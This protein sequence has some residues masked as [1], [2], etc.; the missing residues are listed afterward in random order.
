MTIR[1]PPTPKGCTIMMFSAKSL[2]AAAL[3]TLSL[4]Q[5]A[6]A[7]DRTLHLPLAKAVEAA[8]AAGKLD[9]SVAFYMAGTGPAGRVLEADVVTNKKGNAFA[10][11]D[12]DVCLWVAQSALIQL[13]EA[14]KKVGANAITNLVSYYKKEEYRSRTD[15]E[16]HAGAVIGGVALKGDLS[17]VGK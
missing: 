7:A 10:K 16:C 13:Q 12:E 8:T 9:G 4:V 14:A 17:K 6:S 1:F 11:K 2:T 3:L 5:P 15:F